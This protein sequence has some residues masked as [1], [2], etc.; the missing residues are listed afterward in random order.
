[1]NLKKNIIFILSGLLTIIMANPCLAAQTSPLK[2]GVVSIQQV[3]DGSKAGE[4]ARK[5]LEAKQNELQ[6]KL[7]KEKKA[8]EEEAKEIQKKS[9][10]WSEDKR[11]ETERQYQKKMRAYQLKVDDAQYTMKQLQKKVLAP[12]FK[13]LQ[14]VLDEV[15]KQEGLSIIFE[16]SR[17]NGLLYADESLDITDKVLKKLDMQT[18]AKSK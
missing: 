4:E 15:G 1:M 7:I 18:T 3:I 17:S 2:I 11:Q 14:G 16:K 5:E 9:S 6:P 12:I 13:Q 10:V 8:L